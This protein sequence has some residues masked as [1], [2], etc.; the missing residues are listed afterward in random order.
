MSQSVQKYGR[1]I[2]Y[3]IVLV[4]VAWFL[5][6]HMTRKA[7]REKYLAAVEHINAQTFG[8]AIPL[9]KEAEQ[10]ARKG[11]DTEALSA[12]AK[13]LAM[14]Y[15]GEGRKLTRARKY[16]DA[17]PLLKQVHKYDKEIAKKDGVYRHIGECYR[18]KK[19]ASTKTAV[20]YMKKAVEE[21]PDDS[22]AKML[23]KQYEKRLED[24]KKKT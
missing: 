3:L 24:L 8:E 14:A 16:D 4:G 17:L 1:P 11:S 15:S 5:N 2:F 18:K 13:H 23:L 10:K 12:I 7:G 20:K 9:L 6:R 21:N 19:K 22:M